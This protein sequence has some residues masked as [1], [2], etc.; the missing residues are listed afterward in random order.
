MPTPP[1]PLF[2]TPP[3]GGHA[4]AIRRRPILRS[5][6]TVTSLRGISS[7]LSLGTLLLLAHR[8]GGESTETDAL[9]MGRVLSTMLAI[10]LARAFSVSL[11]PVLTR[12]Q[13][14]HGDPHARTCLFHFIAGFGLWL[15]AATF[16]QLALAFPLMRLLGRGFTDAQVFSSSHIHM[17]NA[18]LSLVLGLFAITEAYL[19]TRG[20]FALTEAAALGMPI[21]T[22]AGLL[23][24][25][26]HLGIMGVPIGTVTGALAGLLMLML[27]LRQTG[28]LQA[29]SD[30][31][32]P[33]CRELMPH[34]LPVVWGGTAGQ[35]SGAVVR[36]LATTLGVGAVSILQYGE[37]AMGAIPM[38][39]ATAIGKVLLPRL[40]AEAATGQLRELGRTVE[41]SIRIM[42][43]VFV[44][45]SAIVTI[46]ND[47]L[48]DLLFGH[49]RFGPESVRQVALVI[50]CFSPSVCC[51]AI[52]LVLMR[53][54]YAL[55]HSRIILT[56]ASAF[57]VLHISFSYALAGPF[58]VVGLAA[59]YSLAFLIQAILMGVLLHRRIGKF[60]GIQEAWWLARCLLASILAGVPMLFVEWQ[61]GVDWDRS[62]PLSA[63]RYLAA[64]L[65][66]APLFFALLHVLGIEEVRTVVRR[67][68]RRLRHG[69]TR[70]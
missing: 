13:I 6:L 41:L 26:P 67:V 21:G 48:A 70:S 32:C 39:A 44:P 38:M 18:P 27:A 68:G 10:Q 63:A 30:F 20:R 56:T 45:Y 47:P 60:V 51:G 29:T 64:L 7:F 43:L 59:A 34:F 28:P 58:G 3:D 40:S 22:L 36:S 19:N 14:T 4:A 65:A 49:G 25:V 1:A 50:A 8:F 11:V 12:Q 61:W 54:F 23:V 15:V 52:T 31:A 42:L 69:G 55:Q 24:W 16:L 9:F 57:L 46:G 35:I 53:T 37:R 33:S 17:M 66:Y 62:Q 5:A 2:S